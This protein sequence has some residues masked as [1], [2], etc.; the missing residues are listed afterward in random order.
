VGLLQ[1]TWPKQ[2]SQ[3]LSRE[4]TWPQQ[5]STRS[6]KGTHLLPS[7]PAARSKRCMMG[8]VSRG[9]ARRA[10]SSKSLSGHVHHICIRP[11]NHPHQSP[12]SGHVHP[13]SA[14]GP[15]TT[16]IKVLIRPCAPQV[17][18]RPANHPHQSPDQAM[19][20]TSASAPQPQS[21]YQ[22]MHTTS[23]HVR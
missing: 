17:C 9:V 2:D 15:P 4:P 14:S 16:L 20:T 3:C 8:G 1:P 10:H 5:K 6:H 11:A 21:P 22:A 18:I 7:W 13:R 23:A 19:R 12:E